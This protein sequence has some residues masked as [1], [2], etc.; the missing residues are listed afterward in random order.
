L[1]RDDDARA[2]RHVR[3]LKHATVLPEADHGRAREDFNHRF[4]SQGLEAFRREL[5]SHSKLRELASLHRRWRAFG[6]SS[7]SARGSRFV[8]R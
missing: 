8:R 3:H 1:G 2:S 5:I 6:G 7:R 4:L